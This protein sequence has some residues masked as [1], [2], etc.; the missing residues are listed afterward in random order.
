MDAPD[1]ASRRTVTLSAIIDAAR[2]AL[3]A[4]EEPQ[5][6]V[7]LANARTQG[8]VE[9]DRLTTELA[10]ARAE[11]AAREDTERPDDKGIIVCPDCGRERPRDT[12]GPTLRQHEELQGAYEEALGRAV[13]A[14]QAFGEDRV[15]VQDTEQEPKP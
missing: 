14:E 4:R 1:S 8:R 3:A 2:E 9:I 5:G 13:R 12:E 15:L 11:L 10:D 7:E 6:E